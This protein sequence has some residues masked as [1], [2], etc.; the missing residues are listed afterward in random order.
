M[1]STDM[2][3]QVDLL[4]LGARKVLIADQASSDNTLKSR[5]KEILFL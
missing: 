2:A 5:E 1:V 4:S 3:M